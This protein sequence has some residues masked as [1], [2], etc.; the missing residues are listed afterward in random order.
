MHPVPI[1][2][3]VLAELDA[4]GGL[5]NTAHPLNRQRRAPANPRRYGSRRAQDFA[6]IHASRSAG[7]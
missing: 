5:D 2:D 7:A 6:L 1:A 4:L 3:L